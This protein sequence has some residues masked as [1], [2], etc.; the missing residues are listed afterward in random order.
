MSQNKPSLQQL[1]SRASEMRA[2]LRARIPEANKL[3]RVPDES[4]A[5]MKKA[6]LFRMM[7]PQSFGG[8]E[9][10]PQDFYRVAMEV[11]RGCPSTGWVLSVVGVHNWQLALFPEQAQQDVWGKDPDAIISSS[12][13]PCGKVD[14][15]DGGYRL[16]GHWQFSSG[17]DHCDWAFLGA[18]IPSENEDAPPM[19]YTFLVPRADYRIDDD[20]YTSGLQG[21]GSKGVIVEDVFV[22]AHRVHSFLDGYTCTSPGH[23]INQNPI[24]KLPFGQV[25]I[26]AVSAPSIGAAQGAIDLYCEYNMARI[27]SAG[28]EAKALPASLIVAAEAQAAV[29]T[30]RLKL[31]HAYDTLL[32]CIE[33]GEEFSML[34][35]AEFK[36]DSATAVGTCLAA[37]QQ[38][39]SN[40][41]GRAIYSDNTL[42]GILQDMIAFRQHAMNDADKP[43]RGLGTVMFGGV[44]DD[45]FS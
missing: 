38:L 25:F 29:T 4:I 23:A 16:S 1:L 45:M 35:R 26:R 8:Y 43:A 34:Q 28:M 24:Y 7:Q 27:N 21:S 10:G 30:A 32:G 6:G 19:M 41:G 15:V 22:P 12:Y 11:A 5:E 9:Y 17:S 42:N 44:S 18:I 13:M 40:S 31:Q 37:V 14:I 33:K 20:W 2:D 36:Y 3:R 39:L